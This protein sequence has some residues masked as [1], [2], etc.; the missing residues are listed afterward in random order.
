MTA[1]SRAV[2][3]TGCSSGIGRETAKLFARQGWVVYATARRPETIADL[4]PEGC[5][6]LALD[7]TDEASCAAAVETVVSEHSAVGVLVNNA[8]VNELGAFETVGL[9]R[10]RAMFETNIFGLIRLSQLALPGM[11]RQGWGRIVNV[12]SMNGRFAFPGMAAYCATKHAMVALSDA[13]R[14]E[15]RPFGVDVALI[16]PGMVKTPLA[17]A[18]ASRHDAG[19]DGV[20]AEYNAKVVQTSVTAAD[21]PMV[22][23]ACEPHDVARVI[24]RAVAATGR[25]RTRYRVAPS[26]HILLT[27]RKLLPDT[28][29]DALLRRIVPVPSASTS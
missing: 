21:G 3:V 20:Y 25:P 11:R 1:I 26:A 17:R 6:L 15:V 12:G 19:A 13:L 2:V 5:R 10:V 7:V 23:F 28:A 22:R 27:A 29:F 4:E 14:F 16:E 18:A 9:D 24:L 8:G